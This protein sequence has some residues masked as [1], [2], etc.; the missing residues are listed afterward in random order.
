MTLI[1]FSDGKVVM[2]DGQV[3]SG[4]ACCCGE[5]QCPPGSVLRVTDECAFI[6]PGESCPEGF[7]VFEA[8]TFGGQPYVQC[9]GDLCLTSVTVEEWQ[10][11]FDEN[12]FPIYGC[13]KANCV[14]FDLCQECQDIANANG[15]DTT[16][17]QGTGQRVLD[18]CEE[19]P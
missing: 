7:V 3:G 8:Y 10:A 14:H 11:C 1:T 5:N 18:C 13:A 6:M 16:G 2:Q 15:G 17:L 9:R 12:G 19:F 4:E